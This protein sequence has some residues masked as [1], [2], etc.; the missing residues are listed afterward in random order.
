MNGTCD[1]CA[2]ALGEAHAC[3]E[4]GLRRRVSVLEAMLNQANRRVA[5]AMGSVESL[6]EALRPFALFATSVRDRD[7][8][9]TCV[10]QSGVQGLTVGALQRAYEVLQ[11]NHSGER[12]D[13]AVQLIELAR[14]ADTRLRSYM[15]AL[16]LDW[17]D[18]DYP[19]HMQRI[20][21]FFVSVRE[22][23]GVFDRLS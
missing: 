12:W 4:D 23:L 5:N 2:G 14:E 10:A 18:L 20:Y 11:E 6:R 8:I 13:A 21:S 3:T 7:D 9:L 22:S 15:E 19:A 1:Y 16:R 17:S